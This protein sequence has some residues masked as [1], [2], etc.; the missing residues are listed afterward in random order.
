MNNSNSIYK[1]ALKK[2]EKDQI[3]KPSL[4]CLSVTGPTGPT[5]PAG[6]SA[7]TGSLMTN[8]SANESIQTNAQLSL[9][10][11]VNTSGTGALYDGTNSIT[12]Q[13]N[14][15]YLIQFKTLATNTA[16]TDVG[17]GIYIN[18]VKADPGSVTFTGTQNAP[19]P[20]FVQYNITATAGTIITIK[21]PTNSTVDYNYSNLSLLRIS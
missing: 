18:N 5:G 9:G 1:K 11:L 4:C 14:G 13:E 20:L 17:V 6:T 7:I 19:Y 16:S 10:E 15:T 2:I 12:I 8:N 3:C 21:N